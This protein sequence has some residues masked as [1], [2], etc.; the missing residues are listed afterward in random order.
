MIPFDEKELVAKYM[1][2]AH[3]KEFT[4]AYMA[5][6]PNRVSADKIYSRMANLWARRNEYA[7]VV[8]EKKAA[9]E[10]TA[11]IKRLANHTVMIPAQ[12]KTKAPISN[13]G[14]SLPDSG[15]MLV[16]IHNLL[17]ESIQIQKEQLAI[18]T[19]LAEGKKPE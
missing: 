17:A 8:T 14:S 12:I 11:E 10:R 13:C 6:F 1:N 5:M 4:M 2:N 19:K 7:K 16:K 3:S 15:E 9:D 18:F